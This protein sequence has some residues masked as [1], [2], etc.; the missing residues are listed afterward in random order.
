MCI[1][2]AACIDDPPDRLRRD[3]LTVFPDLVEEIWKPLTG[4]RSNAV[5]HV[6]SVVVKRFLPAKATPLFP[7]DPELE[8]KA[9]EHLSNFQI[10][11]RLLAK[12]PGWVVWR[13]CSGRSWQGEAGLAGLFEKLQMVPR[14]AGL[15]AR[16]MGAEAILADAKGFAPA[17]LPPP[18]V[19]R[20]I[21]LPQPSLLHGDFVP[22]NILA[23]DRGLRL[24]DWQCPAWGDPV[25]D[26]AL[27]LSPAMQR[28]Y[29]G[30]PLLAEEISVI[31]QQLP[32]QMRQRYLALRSALHWRIAAHCALRAERGD[33]GYEE[34]LGLEL[35]AL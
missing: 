9:L 2:N 17:G 8:A 18:P 33:A 30:R 12:G 14:F 35:A 3:V 23:T 34:A 7:N 22:G 25:D 10:A 31:L 1:E 6:G 21:A 15:K 28:L 19:P 27:F 24:I 4:G 20:A 16:P 5:W 11:P 26:L 13:H 32:D 29:R